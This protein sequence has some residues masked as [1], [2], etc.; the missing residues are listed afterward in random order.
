ML[1]YR[2]WAQHLSFEI[3]FGFVQVFLEVKGRFEFN[4]GIFMRIVLQMEKRGR[5]RSRTSTGSY[6]SAMSMGTRFP[7]G[8]SAR[9][10]SRS[11]GAPVTVL[12][13]PS[14]DETK[15]FDTS[16]SFTAAAGADWASTEVPCTNYLT[17]DGTTLGAYTDSALIP[18]AIGAGFGQVVGS[19]YKIKKIRVRGE[20]TSSVTSDSADVPAPQ[21]VRVALVLDTRP[22]GSQAQGEDVFTDIGTAAQNNYSFM[23]MGAGQAGRFRLLKDQVFVMNPAV[24]GTD[25]A[26]TNS[27]VRQGVQ[28]SFTWKPKVPYDVLLKA[29]S[30]TPTVASLSSA[31]IFM[32]CHA[33]VAT[34]GAILNSAARC[35]YQG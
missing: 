29:N 23:A 7:L 33:S 28:F 31:N 3:N 16:Q 14:S 5:S 6:S 4:L 26:N 21:Y 12:Y 8:A 24:A 35:Y 22:N 32:L 18:S 19:K 13:M 34:T 30:A 25:G 20:V 10:R 17:S 2:F 1:L 15:Y 27:I 11:R 9:S